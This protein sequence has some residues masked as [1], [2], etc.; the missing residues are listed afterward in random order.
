MPSYCTSST[1]NVT[2][3]MEVN[4]ANTSA[5]I[6]ILDTLSP[7]WNLMSRVLYKCK[8]IFLTVHQ[9]RFRLPQSFF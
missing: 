6:D 4:L 5:V 9:A 2:T 7:P 1:C 3:L 8:G